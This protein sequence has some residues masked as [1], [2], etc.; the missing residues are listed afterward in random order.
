VQ[1]YIPIS[2]KAARVNAGYNSTDAARLL[3]VSR[4]TLNNYESGKTSPPWDIVEL[5]SELYQYPKGG[6]L[7]ARHST[8]SASKKER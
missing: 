3:G 6:L 2:A 5:M 1:G 4:V 8:K 7:F